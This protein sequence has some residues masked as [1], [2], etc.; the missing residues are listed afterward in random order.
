MGE[1]LLRWLSPRWWRWAPLV[2]A[3]AAMLL[4][5]LVLSGGKG[6]VGRRCADALS[7]AV[8]A[9]RRQRRSIGLV[10]LPGSE[11]FRF[12]GDPVELAGPL[13]VVAALAATPG[14]VWDVVGLNALTQ[15]WHS[16]EHRGHQHWGTR[17]FRLRMWSMLLLVLNTS[18]GVE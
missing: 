13:G 4:V 15:V 12:A 18:L 11:V 1:P 9:R 14:R 6:L 2:S 8:R 5:V 10:R 3:T 17:A 7:G 16:G